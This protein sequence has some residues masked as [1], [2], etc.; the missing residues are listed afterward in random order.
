MREGALAHGEE[1]G[2]GKECGAVSGDAYAPRNSV[3]EGEFVNGDDGD[4]YD[5]A[6]LR[7]DGDIGC[8][9]ECGCPRDAA[10]SRRG[11]TPDRLE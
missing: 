7:E 11:G 4:Q 3:G 8:R 1:D 10:P 5:A 9:S 6:L 2:G